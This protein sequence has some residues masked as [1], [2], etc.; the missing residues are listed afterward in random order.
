M[1]RELSLIIHLPS[2]MMYD[3]NRLLE[4]IIDINNL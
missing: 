4:L 1:N 3:N 2:E